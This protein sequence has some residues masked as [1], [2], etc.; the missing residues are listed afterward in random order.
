MGF[1][2]DVAAL[3]P[4]APAPSQPPRGRLR[5]FC[6]RGTPFLDG[7]NSGESHRSKWMITGSKTI[8]WKAPFVG[9]TMGQSTRKIHYFYGHVQWQ[10]VRLPE[11]RKAWIAHGL[12]APGNQ[13]SYGKE[14]K[15]MIYLLKENYFPVR[16]LSKYV[17]KVT[18]CGCA[19]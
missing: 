11:G 14:M 8:C 10:S 9:K 13:Q 2:R 15:G 5:A 1:P 3:A 4:P 16:K 17:R 6:K 19:S 7:E 12:A 18:H